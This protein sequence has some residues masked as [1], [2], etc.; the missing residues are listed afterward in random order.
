MIL[1]L[2]QVLNGLIIGST[3]AVVAVGFSMVFTVL[4][5]INFAHPDIFMVGMFVGLAAA[6]H[7]SDNI[8]I[9]RAHV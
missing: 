3:Y 5:V 1:F 2:Q 6:L 4:R 8:K 7:V 9:G